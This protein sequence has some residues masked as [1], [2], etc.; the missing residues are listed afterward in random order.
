MRR[1]NPQTESWGIQTARTLSQKTRH[2]GTSTEEGGVVDKMRGEI[3][4]EGDDGKEGRVSIDGEGQEGSADRRGDGD[5]ERRDAGG[6][7]GVVTR[8]WESMR[9]WVLGRLKG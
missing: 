1:P 3:G 4:H 6:R 2:I 9:V 7:S 5:G 8:I